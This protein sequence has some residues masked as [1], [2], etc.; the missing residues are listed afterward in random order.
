[1]KTFLYIFLFFFILNGYSQQDVMSS[2][3]SIETCVADSQCALINNS[4]YL[5]YDNSKTA[6]YFKV[7]FRDSDDSI[8]PWLADLAAVPLYFKVVV[9]EDFFKGP[10]NYGQ[11]NFN[12]TGQIFLNGYW[13]PQTVDVILLASENNPYVINTGKSQYDNFKISFSLAV[14]PEDFRLDE[15]MHHLSE[16]ISIGLLSGRINELRPGMEGLLG[17]AYNHW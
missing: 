14:R 6:L 5:F 9:P 15:R 2:G 10:G 7:N 3:T 1:M 4:G 17:E 8:V 13:Q 11:R 12:L 16:T